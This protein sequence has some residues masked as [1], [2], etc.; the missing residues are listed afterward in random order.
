MPHV[1]QVVILDGGKRRTISGVLSTNPLKALKEVPQEELEKLDVELNDYDA[2]F[3]EHIT[4]RLRTARTEP[5]LVVP[6][7]TCTQS[8]GMSI[9][10]LLDTF[11]VNH[12]DTQEFEKTVRLIPRANFK[13]KTLRYL[14]KIGFVKLHQID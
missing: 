6:V 11:T 12:R 7:Q 14:L 8:T 1:I 9:K 10:K 5:P 3:Q 4:F 2:A 13:P